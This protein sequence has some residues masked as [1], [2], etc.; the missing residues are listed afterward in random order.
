MNQMHLGVQ[1]LELVEENGLGI[2]Q[3]RLGKVGSP[4]RSG[5]ALFADITWED[6]RACP[7]EMVLGGGLH[8]DSDPFLWLPA[9]CP[10]PH[11]MC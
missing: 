7:R 8:S 10:C 9:W 11:C 5:E 6:H 2:K 3:L 1:A 4:S